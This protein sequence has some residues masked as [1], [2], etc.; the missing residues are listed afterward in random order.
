[1][2]KEKK[3]IRNKKEK[4]LYFSLGDY[5]SGK[6]ILSHETTTELIHKAQNGDKESLNQL[7][8]HNGRMILKVIRKNFPYIEKSED[9]DDIFQQGMLGVMTAIQKYDENMGKFSTYAYYW[10][11]QSIMRYLQDNGKSIR[12]PVHA[13]LQISKIKKLQSNYLK[14]HG[15]YPSNKWLAEKLNIKEKKVQELLLYVPNLLSL[16]ENYGEEKDEGSPLGNEIADA[17][18][19]VEN[20]VIQNVCTIDITECMKDYLTERE[21]NIIKLRYGFLGEAKTLSDISKIYK[22]SRERIRQIEAC[23]IKKLQNEKVK[24]RLREYM[25]A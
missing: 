21:L 17:S 7:C 6:K 22:L 3:C 20:E 5:C 10:I 24:E 9:I 2:V 19:N 11:H 1:M 14:E 23:A 13:G 18:V 12:I 8:I 15:E 25:I 4:A 16:D